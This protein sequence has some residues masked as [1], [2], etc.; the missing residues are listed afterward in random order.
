MG[1]CGIVAVA[2][3]TEV[4]A[5]TVGEGVGGRAGGAGRSGKTEE[6]VGDMVVVGEGG[7]RVGRGS[8]VGEGS[9]GGVA[10]GSCEEPI[11]TTN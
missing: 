5:A 10:V 8:G 11:T 9:I 1:V 2:V 3:G 4:G 7:I 6:L